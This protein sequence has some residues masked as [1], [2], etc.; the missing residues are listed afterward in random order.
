MVRSDCSDCWKKLANDLIAQ[1]AQVDNESIKPS[2]K[3]KKVAV[4]QKQASDR[5]KKL[6][7]EREAA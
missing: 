3:L 2:K 5:K 4:I 6:L 7:S 1:L